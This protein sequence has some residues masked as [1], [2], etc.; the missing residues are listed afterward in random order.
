MTCGAL[1]VTRARLEHTP[2]NNT[3][4]ETIHDALGCMM[5]LH[6]HFHFLHFHF[7]HGHHHHA[8]SIRGFGSD[9]SAV[10]VEPVV[11]QLGR[12]LLR[13]NCRLH[14]PST[15]DVDGIVAAK[16]GLSTEA[17][18]S[19]VVVETAVK[20]LGLRAK[21]EVRGRHCECFRVGVGFK[22]GYDMC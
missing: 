18:R 6:F 13:C 11:Q 14:W 15:M 8:R 9:A 1:K 22:G 3:K 21:R 20:Q 5:H 19:A 2:L 4:H 16:H 7:L 12:R 17:G 10:A